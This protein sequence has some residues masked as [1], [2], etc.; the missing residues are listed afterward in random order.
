MGTT[1]KGPATHQHHVRDWRDAELKKLDWY[2]VR[3]ISHNIDI[4]TNVLNYMQVL[5]DLPNNVTAEVDEAGN[6][7]N[8]NTFPRIEVI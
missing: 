3:K 8:A 5:R 6:L 2:V 7:T 4:P 1:I